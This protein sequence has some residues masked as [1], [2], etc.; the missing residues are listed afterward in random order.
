MKKAFAVAA[1]LVLVCSSFAFATDDFLY[2]GV[3]GQRVNGSQ[4]FPYE[5]YGAW[6]NPSATLSLSLACPAP[7][8]QVTKSIANGWVKVIDKHY[9]A[10]I[11]ARVCVPYRN[12]S[13]G[14]VYWW[15]WLMTSTGSGP[16]VQHL[17][18]GTVG[19]NTISPAYYYVVLPPTYNGNASCLISYYMNEN[20]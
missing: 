7:R 3:M 2:P 9:S 14:A 18:H 1:L 10:N 5:S 20:N 19:T 13:N 8:D 16:Q 6:C 17:T 4:P 15:N 12:A 11:T